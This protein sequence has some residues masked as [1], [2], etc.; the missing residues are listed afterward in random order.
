M[1]DPKSARRGLFLVFVILFLD[2]MGIAIITPV[3]PAYLEE[4]TGATISEAAVEG[5]W[6]LLVYSGMQLLFAPLIGNLSDRF[7]RRPVLLASVL[8]FALDNLIC[9]LATTYWMLFVGRV[10]AGISGASFSTA[11]AYIADVSDDSNRAKNFGLI[12]I[13]FGT[14]FALGPVLGGILGEFGPRIPFYGAAALSFINFVVAFFL[15]PETLGKE[16][17]R[18]FEWKRANPLGAVK[19]MRNYPG[20]GWILLVFFL[21]WQAHAVYPAVW[22]FVTSE[23]YGWSE[24]QIGLSLGI[25]GI[26]G[27]LVMG[28]VLPRVVPRLGE[29]KSGAVGLAFTGLGLFG[30]AL[31]FQ[32]WMVYAVILLTCIEALADP[33]LR[34]IAA[35]RVPPSA[36]GELQ[37]ALSS[38]SSFTTIIGPL[39]FTQI[40]SSFTAPGA[41]VHFA[42]APY[43]LSG[44]FIVLALA[45]YLA[46]LRP[47]PVGAALES[48]AS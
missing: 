14:G 26:C 2:I 12:G 15:L 35:A 13:A 36:Q 31:A 3:L 25:F 21:Y 32:G 39:M 16:H 9:A 46:K 29:W 40:F 10:L 28:F 4:L 34:S 48:V 27:A 38:I 17:R 7:G 22:S 6:L 41:T 45:V 5:G 11:S 18:R 43:V 8:T 1:I 30:Y 47:M 23:R 24:G 37:G 20:I 42:G 33:P 19:Q 44:F